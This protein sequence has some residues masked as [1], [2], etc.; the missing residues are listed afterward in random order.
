ML[1]CRFS[2]KNADGPFQE[3]V[4][5]I[6]FRRMLDDNGGKESFNFD[7]FS[8]LKRMAWI[9]SRGAG[10]PLDPVIYKLSTRSQ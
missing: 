9:E 10:S 4:K 2:T 6:R 7:G 8:S 1:L 5:E 3:R